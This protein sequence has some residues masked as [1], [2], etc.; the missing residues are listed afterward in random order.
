MVGR[1]SSPVGPDSSN[2]PLIPDS[3][4]PCIHTKPAESQALLFQQKIQ[5]R[6]GL[7][8]EE[9]GIISLQSIR[10]IPLNVLGNLARQTIQ[11]QAEPRM[12]FSS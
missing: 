3:D 8:L 4:A 2:T 11:H 12:F 5:P 6:A 1:G 7:H 9:R 10:Y